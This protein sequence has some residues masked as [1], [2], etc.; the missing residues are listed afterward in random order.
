MKTLLTLC[1]T[2]FCL[3]AW[4]QTDISALLKKRFELYKELSAVQKGWQE[5]QQILRGEVKLL[6]QN[7]VRLNAKKLKLSQTLKSES[8]ALVKLNKNIDS[9]Q[10]FLKEFEAQ[11]DLDIAN[12]FKAFDKLPNALQKISLPAKELSS[13][14]GKKQSL[15]QKLRLLESFRSDLFQLQQGLHQCTETVKIKGQDLEVNVIYLGTAIGYYLSLDAKNAGLMTPKDG[16]WVQ[17]ERNE[18]AA[19]ILKAR[20]VLNQDIAPEILRLPLIGAKK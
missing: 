20:Q 16:T 11:V 9:Q 12:A 19:E 14:K 1:L 15:I 2:F 13:L 7:Q 3:Q 4:S 6:Q 18:L 5:E 10:K 8:E 17:I